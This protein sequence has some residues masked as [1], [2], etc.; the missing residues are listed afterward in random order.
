MAT[1]NKDFRVKNGLI[2][3]G[4]TGTIN[5]SNILTEASTTFIDNKIEDVAGAL[6]AGASLT[7][8]QVS[9]DNV[10]NALSITA[11]NGVGDSTTDNLTEGSTNL[12]FTDE[13]AQDAIGTAITGGTQTNITV[14]YDDENNVYNF[15][16][17]N[18]VADSTTTDLAEGTN[19]YFTNQRALDAT[20]AAYDP[21]GS[22][23][24]AESNAIATAAADATTKANTAEGN[25]ISAAAADATTKA[26]TAESN[27]NTY[28]DDLIGD[29]TVDG[30]AGDT[31][32]D[33]IASSVSTHSGLSTGVHGVTGDVVG[34]SDSQTL[35]NKTLG[36]DLNADGNQIAN[37]AE[38]TQTHHAA[39]KNY[40]DTAVTG[41]TWKDAVNLLADSN[42][43]VSADF[44][45][46][47]IDGHD[48]LTITDAGYRLLLTGQTVDAENGIYV[49]TDVAGALQASRATDADTAAE[50]VDA[51][52]LI[53]EGT[54]Y[55][56][57]T[58][59]QSNHY[60]T[61]F[62]N[63]T[64]VRFGGTDLYTT[65]N[66]LQ[67]TGN[68]FSIDT[69]VT[70]DVDSAQTLSN[71]TLGSDLDA[72]GSQ[73][74]NLGTPTADGDAATK[75]YVDNAVTTGVG[76]IDTDDVP[77]GSSNLYF[78]DARAVAALEAVVPDFTEVDINSVATQVAATQTVATAGQ[79]TA[80]SFDSTVY[81]SAKFL[82]K[83]ATSTHTEVS[84]VLLTLD[85]SGNVAM[86]EY[87]I[88]GTNGTLATTTATEAAGLAELLV[89]T[90]NNSSTVTVMGTLLK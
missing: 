74:T 1:V 57:S 36:D 70:V 6:L 24:T 42:V 71:K 64:W 67:T 37:L 15:V 44:V 17:E 40:V 58:W 30:T 13:R 39:T 18:G 25:A 35:T 61:D 56:T 20:A 59:V 76:N 29:A 88:V 34:T 49:L 46:V 63:Q 75:L 86:T 32:T 55:G 80:Y 22:A 38:P 83:V 82:I 21:A 52:V 65:G 47:V 19:L 4:T 23:A 14:T 90:V 81:R 16:A 3:E 78:Q 27:A 66:G 28:T 11:E 62:T 54:L 41:L 73:V 45:G 5:G 9:Y 84:E 72:D 10:T 53:Q 77:E 68:E 33:R 43:D 26:N 89:T 31:V 51:A 87:A 85:S 2:V 7:N 48:P 60:L 69:A 12:Y 79:V 8:I 50:L